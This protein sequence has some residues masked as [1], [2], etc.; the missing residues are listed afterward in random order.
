[1]I[2]LRGDDVPALDCE[3]EVMVDLM[4]LAQTYVEWYRGALGYTVR[5]ID[6]RG[7]EPDGDAINVITSDAKDPMVAIKGAFTEWS[8]E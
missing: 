1:M 3:A 5:V 7:S 6:M 2:L 4:E 8:G